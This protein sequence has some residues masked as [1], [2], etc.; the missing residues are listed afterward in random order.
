MRRL[1]IVPLQEARQV[2][3]GPGAGLR[4]ALHRIRVPAPLLRGARMG[5]P[6]AL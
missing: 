2:N 1:G 5:G 3:S 4:S 6:D